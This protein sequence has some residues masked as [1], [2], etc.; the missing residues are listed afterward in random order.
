MSDDLPDHVVSVERVFGT[1]YVRFHSGRV[2]TVQDVSRDAFAYLTDVLV[3]GEP[4]SA[5]RRSPFA[6]QKSEAVGSSAGTITGSS[7]GTI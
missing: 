4:A 2:D 7:S 6:R 3:R 1:A 5:L